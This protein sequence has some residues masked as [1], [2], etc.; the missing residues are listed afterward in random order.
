V[1]RQPP[2]S[3]PVPMECTTAMEFGT[4]RTLAVV[5]LPPFKHTKPNRS[6]IWSQGYVGRV[7]K[8]GRWG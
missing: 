4:N 1:R 8:P 3:L 6:L 5:K 2:L 7:A